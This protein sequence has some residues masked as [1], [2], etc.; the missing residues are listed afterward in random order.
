MSKPK[1]DLGALVEQSA[2][3]ELLRVMIGVAADGAGGRGQGQGEIGRE[4][5]RA[6]RSA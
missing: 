5:G 1:L 4:V 6:H 3:A 2:E